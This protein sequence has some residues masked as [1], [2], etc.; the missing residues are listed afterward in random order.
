[1]R[2]R[3]SDR[4]HVGGDVRLGWELHLRAVGFVGVSWPRP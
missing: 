3:V 4:I 2:A 1:V